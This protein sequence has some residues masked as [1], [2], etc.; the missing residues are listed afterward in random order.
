MRYVRR[1]R[2]GG[3]LGG[4]LRHSISPT[5]LYIMT[6]VLVLLVMLPVVVALFKPVSV[7]VHRI[8]PDLLIEVSNK[9]RTIAYVSVEGTAKV[10]EPLK[11]WRFGDLT[12]YKV[13]IDAET[14]DRLKSMKNVVSI[15]GAKKFSHAPLYS[16]DPN[17][18]PFREKDI[19]NEFHKAVGPWVGRGVTVA[20]ID[21]GIDY[22]HPDFYDEDNRSVIKALASILYVSA[23]TGEYLFW[24]PY[25][26]GTM[27][28]L[29]EFD[30]ELW[31]QHGEP[32]FLDINGHGCVTP[33]TVVWTTDTGPIRIEDLWKKY[34]YRAIDTSIEGIPAK[35]K[36]MEKTV[37]TLGF[38]ETSREFTLTKILAIHR[39]WYNGSL[40]VVKLADGTILKLTPWHPVYVVER[41]RDPYTGKIS[42]RY[43]GAVRAEQLLAYK[44]RQ[45]VR[46][47]FI[48]AP[49]PPEYFWRNVKARLVYFMGL[50]YGDGYVRKGT[51]DIH[52]A[53]LEAVKRYGD[54]AESLGGDIRIW[55]S[56]NSN[57]YRLRVYMRGF[58][59]IYREYVG[60]I[61]EKILSD[62]D[63][64]RAFISGLFDADGYVGTKDSVPEVKIVSKNKQILEDLRVFLRT[65][66][67]DARIRSGGTTK[68]GNATT[69]HLVIT[70]RANI[71]RFY[72]LIKD[73]S[74]NP[75]VEKLK[76]ILEGADP[77]FTTKRAIDLGWARA[78]AI[79][80]IKVEHYTGWLYDFTTET[81]NYVGNGFI[82]HNTHVAGI[83]AGRGWASSGKYLG[84]APATE[85]V[86]VKAF[87]KD[88]VA[89]ID[90]CLEALEWVY[91]NTEKYDIKV[92]SLSWGASFASDG[93]DPVSLAVNKIAGKGVL[94][95][96][97]AGNEGN[98]P[99]TVVVPAVAERAFAVGAWDPYHDELAPFS[100]IGPTIDMRMKPDLVTAGVMIVS[101]KSQYVDYPDEYE[102][103]DYYV[104]L[105]GT[106]MSTPVAAGIAAD[107]IEY[108]RYWNGR[109]PT[110]NE[111]IAWLDNNARH[112][113]LVKDFVTGWGIPIAPHT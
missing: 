81:S 77:A 8:D 6:V 92:L 54:I 16:L 109:D 20:I 43:I 69:W 102:V 71:E 87:N 85:L 51:I 35:T 1:R 14:L 94:V 97:A 49:I 37:F 50:V 26:N 31:R 65:I 22:T 95:F 70:K 72:K 27:D 33:D 74:V 78:V 104:A 18:Y 39:I 44:S 80:D 47:H 30:M 88:G 48:L 41:V 66:G 73:Y 21:T 108:F 2:R 84:V 100:S 79:V 57:A 36:I 67:I 13:Y 32:A 58:E 111:F 106:S 76:K 90:M 52:D 40:I 29:L 103:G 110:F 4:G 96:V 83:V 56:S 64:A 98:L 61:R 93:K 75:K 62:I 86:I 42:Y 24:E 28:D 45:Q 15:Y 3:S 112:I 17:E 10:S 55:K 25:K 38:N 53:S 12:I 5:I 7:I 89:S 19:D 91:N 59:K 11:V 68:N 82:V 113:N 34:H 101:C 46:S 63:L 99:T 105:S 9:G 60:S 23:S 107:F